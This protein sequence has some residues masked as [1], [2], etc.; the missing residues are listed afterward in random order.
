M[1]IRRA[2]SPIVGVAL[3]KIVTGLDL[4]IT[5]AQWVNGLYSV[6]FAALL[7][8]VGRIGDR[9]GRKR[10]FIAGTAIFVVGSILAALPTRVPR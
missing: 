7:L 6:V 2:Q 9:I 10:I 8:S 4:D 1:R 3:P 5:D